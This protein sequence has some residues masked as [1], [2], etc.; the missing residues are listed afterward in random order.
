ML[1]LPTALLIAHGNSVN[2]CAHQQL[3]QESDYFLTS[4]QE[5]YS[6]FQEGEMLFTQKILD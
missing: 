6:G 4:L 1:A 5:I 3:C 2:I